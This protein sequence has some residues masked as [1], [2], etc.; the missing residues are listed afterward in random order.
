MI[1]EQINTVSA[2]SPH[3]SFKTCDLNHCFDRKAK[4]CDFGE[5]NDIIFNEFKTVCMYLLNKKK[6]ENV[7]YLFPVYTLTVKQ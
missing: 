7:I 1:H 5:T 6:I 4:C 3:Q 2:N